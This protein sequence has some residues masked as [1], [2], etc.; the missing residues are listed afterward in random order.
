MSTNTPNQPTQL[1]QPNQHSSADLTAAVDYVAATL[2]PQWAR[3]L[4]IRDSISNGGSIPTIS[5]AEQVIAI[6]TDQTPAG[7]LKTAQAQAQTIV[8]EWSQAAAVGTSGLGDLSAQVSRLFS[9]SASDSTA[10]QQASGQGL[11]GLL[12]SLGSLTSS[13]GAGY[14]TALVL[15]VGEAHAP[16]G[17]WQKPPELPGCRTTPR[18]ATRTAPTPTLAPTLAPALVLVLP[19]PPQ[20]KPHHP[21]HTCAH[22]I[23]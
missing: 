14:A 10:S 23:R 16:A 15:A 1:T 12:G 4:D 6:I 20:P 19:T 7:A 11:A 2:S 13:L 21:P 18:T 3:V 5:E 22:P 8:T 9:G 17:A